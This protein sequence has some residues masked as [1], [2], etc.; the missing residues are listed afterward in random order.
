M[1]HSLYHGTTW[2]RALALGVLAVLLGGCVGAGKPNARV[3]GVTLQSVDV[4][5]DAAVLGVEMLVENPTDA[6]LTMRASRYTA[7]VDDASYSGRWR[8]QVTAPAGSSNRY[9]A[10]VVASLSALM[11]ASGASFQVSGSLSYLE[12]DQLAKTLWNIGIRRP[13]VAFGGSATLLPIS[14]EDPQGDVGRSLVAPEPEPA[15]GG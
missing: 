12:P 14:R 5:A 1:N 9:T 10:P 4:V 15:S 13:E 3:V 6:D 2:A 11:D 7:R 8:P